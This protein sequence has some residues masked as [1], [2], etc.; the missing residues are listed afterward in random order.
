MAHPVSILVTSWHDEARSRILAALSDQKD[1]FVAGIEKDE[2]S[3]IIKSEHIKPDILILDL[4][5]SGTIGPRIA[6]MI[7]RRSPSTAIV[8]I[9]DKDE[10]KYAEQALKAGISGFLLKEADL[11][12][13]VPILK[14]VLN[15]GYYFSASITVRVFNSFIP[16]QF[17]GKQINKQNFSFSP[18][19][20]G[21][22]THIAQGYSDKEIAKHLNY[23]TGTIKN[24]VTAIKHK[25]K[26][27]NRTQIATFSIV[28]GLIRLEHLDIFFSEN[29]PMMQ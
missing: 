2:A 9:C 17:Y 29:F 20:R 26:L 3:A 15:G 11:D 14:I 4:K 12:K 5:L 19:E 23:S 13:L 8:L 18:A 28:Y 16:G 1:F 6:P 10:V 22:I 27:K 24:C 21:I 25:T 7:H